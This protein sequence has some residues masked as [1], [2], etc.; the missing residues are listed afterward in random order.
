MATDKASKHERRGK[1][2]R[3]YHLEHESMPL[4][5]LLNS[6]S[7]P[8]D[9]VSLRD[10]TIKYLQLLEAKEQR[11]RMPQLRRA[12]RVPEELPAPFGALRT[13]IE[14]GTIARIKK[15]VCGTYF[16]KRLPKQQFCSVECRVGAD[17]AD[18]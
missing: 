9:L 1:P 11:A 6:D 4:L 15:C 2:E 5:N 17:K 8:K 3:R 14:N 10:L 12:G 18:S 7:P 13:A 16:F